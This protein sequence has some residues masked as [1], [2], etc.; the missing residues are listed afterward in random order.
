MLKFLAL[1]CPKVDLKGIAKGINS[2]IPTKLHIFEQMEGLED[3]FLQSQKEIKQR[4]LEEIRY[5][6]L[7]EESRKIAE[8]I[9]DKK[10]AKCMKGKEATQFMINIEE[11][12]KN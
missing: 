4:F 7:E 1:M 2:Q 3:K 5:A 9:F 6:G 12:A 11:Y 8:E 10:N